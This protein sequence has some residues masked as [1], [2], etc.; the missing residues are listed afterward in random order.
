MDIIDDRDGCGLLGGQLASATRNDGTA[1]SGLPAPSAAQAARRIKG[2]RMTIPPPL[3]L[4]LRVGE[5]GSGFTGANDGTDLE[6]GV[7]LN[8]EPDDEE[9]AAMRCHE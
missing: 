8:G 5:S 1:A 6:I 4:R 3:Q 2:S 9:L 7:D